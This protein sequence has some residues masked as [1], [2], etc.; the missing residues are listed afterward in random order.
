MIDRI[1]LYRVDKE[2][3]KQ[4]IA[5][6]FDIR[7]DHIN[8]EFLEF[9]ENFIESKSSPLEYFKK[10]IEF[11]S[12]PPGVISFLIPKIY[13]FINV[14]KTTWMTI[15]L[16]LDIFVT[17]G[18]TS[19]FLSSLGVIGRSIAKL[20]LKNGEVCCYYEALSLKKEGIEKFTENQLLHRISNKKCLNL[21]F[22]CVYNKQGL[23]SINS[24]DL[25]QV[26]SN[27]GE[28]SVLSKT[29]DGKWRVEL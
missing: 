19:A 2:K 24:K 12:A 13:Y 17:K 11:P 23:C 4:K 21:K 29:E 10:Q 20:N 18:V 16:L 7:V 9:I 15:G 6:D 22:N 26:I 28:K 8:D 5:R 1:Y 25:Q 27:L 14:K 3:L